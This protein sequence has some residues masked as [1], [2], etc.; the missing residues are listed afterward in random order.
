M[1]Y[2]LTAITIFIAIT[3]YAQK[4]TN[5]YKYQVKLY[6]LISP[7]RESA[8]VDLKRNTLTSQTGISHFFNPTFA[9][10]RMNK[11]GNRHELELTSLSDNEYSSR[12]S[13]SSDTARIWGFVSDV[14]E[15]KVAIRYEYIQVFLKNRKLQPSLGFAASPYFVKYRHTPQWSNFNPF[16]ERV[17]GIQTFIV[18][19]LNINISKRFLLDVNVPIRISEHQFSK[20]EEYSS[21]TGHLTIKGTNTVFFRDMLY[22]RFGAGLNI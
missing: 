14:R 15:F 12:T 13:Y 16:T 9:V 2:I 6:G 8:N 4:P 7:N 17:F 1:K 18:P 21:S 10:N 11:R 19:R 22:I 5:G 20:R 3:C